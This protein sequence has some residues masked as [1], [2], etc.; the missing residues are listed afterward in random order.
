[1]DIVFDLWN[2]LAARN[3]SLQAELEAE[4]GI[5]MAMNNYRLLTKTTNHTTIRALV[6]AYTRRDPCLEK[7]IDKLTQRLEKVAQ[8]SH[9]LPGTLE[10]L[11]SLSEKYSL[12]ILGNGTRIM[13]E[14]VLQQL[15][16]YVDSIT[17]S[18]DL[19]IVKP[20]PDF[21][22]LWA[23]RQGIELS[24]CIYFDDMQQGVDAASSV[25]MSAYRFVSMRE[26]IAVLRDHS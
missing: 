6:E 18:S 25:G 3:H 9:I 20:D 14:P 21:F 12:H 11:D 15:E 13:A 2:V 17:L 26:T 4:T 7:A 10:A 1:M 5:S 16:P 23:Q 24:K 22:Y 19:G 8:E